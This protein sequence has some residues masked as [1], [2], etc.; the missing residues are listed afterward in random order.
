MNFEVK[1]LIEEKVLLGRVAR[2]GRSGDVG[3]CCIESELTNQ[4]AKKSICG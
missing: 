1:S 3:S 2:E 4:S